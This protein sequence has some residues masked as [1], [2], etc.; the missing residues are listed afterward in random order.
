VAKPSIVTA[1]ENHL[2]AVAAIEK[3]AHTT[4]WRLE[5]FRR[6]LTNP[7]GLFYVACNEG[8]VIGYA[9]AWVIVDEAHIVNVAVEAEHRGQGTGRALVAQLLEETRKRGATCATLEVREGNEAAIGL[10]RSFGF[11]EAGVRKRYY[12]GI[13]NAVIMWLHEIPA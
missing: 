4:P 6:E 7:D 1:S 8:K 10:Y 9:L 12:Q 2:E 5:S 11:E 3:D 13:A